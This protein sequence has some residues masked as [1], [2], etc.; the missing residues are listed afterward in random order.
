MKD[1]PKPSLKPEALQDSIL[2]AVESLCMV[3]MGLEW[4]RWDVPPYT[5]SP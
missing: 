1:K 3:I 4:I 2:I 5:I